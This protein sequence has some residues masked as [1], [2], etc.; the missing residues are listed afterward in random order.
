MNKGYPSQEN[1]Y[2]FVNNDGRGSSANALVS[3]VENQ[4]RGQS[5][6]S[7]DHDSFS[8]NLG[9]ESV[10]AKSQ[11]KHIKVVDSIESVIQN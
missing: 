5:R 2:S 11:S 6:A 8:I 3:L 4:S 10:L 9:R 7:F 1:S